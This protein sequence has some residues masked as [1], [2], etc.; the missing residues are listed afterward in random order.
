MERRRP[1]AAGIAAIAGA[2]AAHRIERFVHGGSALTAAGRRRS[3][4][5]Q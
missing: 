5:A 4:L 3:G 2:A 1:A